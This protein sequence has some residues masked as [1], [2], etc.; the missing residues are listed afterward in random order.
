MS[1]ER[2]R[3]EAVARSVL[4]NVTSLEVRRRSMPMSFL[5]TLIR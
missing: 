1:D 2:C 4:C 5:I 3:I